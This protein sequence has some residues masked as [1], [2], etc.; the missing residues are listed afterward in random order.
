MTFETNSFDM[1]TTDAEYIAVLANAARD[2]LGLY[3]ELKG[4]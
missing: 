4:P 3:F 2:S 1:V